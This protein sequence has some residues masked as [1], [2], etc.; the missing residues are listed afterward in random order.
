VVVCTRCG[1]EAPEDARFCPACGAEIAAEPG[2]EVRKTVTLLFAD[3]TGSTALGEKL[4]P[5]SLRR[6]MSRYH[7]AVRVVLERH[8]GSVEKFVGDAVMAVFG[9]P[10]LHEDDALRAVRAADEMRE[11]LAALNEELR[12]QPGVEIAIRTGINTGEVVV[13][14]GETLAVGDAVN[15]AARL[16]QVAASDEILLGSETYRLV[17]DA[18]D[19]EEVEP[20]ELKGK[21]APVAAYRLLRVEPGAPGHARH[22]DSPMVGRERELRALLEAFER[23]VGDRACHLFTVLGAAGVGKSRLVEEFLGSVGDRATVVRGRCLPYGEGITFWPLAEAL[24]QAARLEESDSPAEA[25]A[26]LAALVEA[27]E[28][29]ELIERRVAEL[30]GLEEAT[31]G[32]EEGF[33]GV[34]KLLESLARRHPVVVVFDDV[35]WAEPTFLDLVEHVSDWVRDAAILLVCL[36]RPELLEARPAWGGGKLNATSV[37]LEALSETESDHLIQ[38]LLGRA[39]LAEDVR[40]RIAEAA[41][42]NPLFVEEMLAMLIDE[43]LLRRED[44]GWAPTADL[45]TLAVPPTIQVLL[46][47]RLDRLEAEEREVI[48]RA[49]VEG[50]VF[51]RGSVAE[52]SPESLRPAVPGRLLA[53]VRKELIR[54]DRAVFAGEDAFRFRHLLIRDA[55]YEAMPKEARAELHERFAAWLAERVGDR[56]AEYEEVLGYHLEQACRYRRELS[57]LDERT[58][59]LSR[60]AAD[61]LAAA[62]RRANNRG[63]YH[64]ALN[65]L[66][67]AESVLPREAAERIALVPDLIWPLRQTGT[68]EIGE[69][70]FS[71]LTDSAGKRGDVLETAY[72]DVGRVCFDEQ[73]SPREWPALAEREAHRLAPIF[74]E[75]RDERGLALVWFLR[76][77]AHWWRAEYGEALTASQ[78][79]ERHARN[80]GDG[81]LEQLAI[82]WKFATYVFGPTQA[83]EAARRCVEALEREETDR[84]TA[85][86]ALAA[87]CVLRAMEGRF[88]EARQLVSSMRAL[89]AELGATPLRAAVIGE[90]LGMIENIAG[91]YEAAERAGSEQYRVLEEMGSKDILPTCAGFLADHVYAQGKYEEADR[92]THISEDLAEEEDLPSQISW[93]VTRAR[94]LAQRGDPDAE[95]IAREAIALAEKTDDYHWHGNAELALAEVLRLSG[96]TDEAVAAAERGLALYERKGI[97]PLV[98]RTRALISELAEA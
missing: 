36:A 77:N 22:L 93:R 31:A 87:L 66:L 25:R 91:D 23:A 60:R 62:G 72:V 33:W 58:D 24:R 95:R 57:L 81:A 18:V 76:R 30:I 35:H 37:L 5:E 54:P 21:S 53:L 20:L 96:R 59:E 85:Y 42:G 73:F 41:D 28:D 12:R 34:R 48:E 39:A 68:R 2:R 40:A 10:V 74:E 19:V 82:H 29:G 3:M 80:A 98:E 46:A 86:G 45:S 89:D 44:G 26:K 14:E 67:R 65:L 47:A 6:V 7:D 9:V 61:R 27:E 13:G 90:R 52:L 71:E 49:S 92:L 51:H 15:V 55:A 32:V 75:A 63:D 78:R 43:G 4:D 88:A 69:A 50:K 83:D 1:K 17:R 94:V 8:G 84:S 16:E 97:V 56:L 70:I 38:N 64:A 79:M 11:A